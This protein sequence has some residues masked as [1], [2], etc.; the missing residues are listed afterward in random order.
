[1]LEILA[2]Q[3]Y[4]PP[5]FAPDEGVWHHHPQ[6]KEYGI[7]PT[8]GYLRRKTRKKTLSLAVRSGN[9]SCRTWGRSPAIWRT[10]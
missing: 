7:E 1:M 4:Y 5:L 3:G 10:G 9:C 6:G 8:F 2:A